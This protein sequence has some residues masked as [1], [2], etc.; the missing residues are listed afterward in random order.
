MAQRYIDRESKRI[1]AAARVL[2]IRLQSCLQSCLASFEW[3][4][5]GQGAQVG[6]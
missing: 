5:R 3:G 4:W 6:Q 1:Q 2:E